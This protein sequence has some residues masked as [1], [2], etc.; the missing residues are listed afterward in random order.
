MTPWWV[1]SP[2]TL[3][4]VR[5]SNDLTTL[6]KDD[7]TTIND[8][9]NNSNN[10]FSE[11]N[12]N[13]P[14]DTKNIEWSVV[15]LKF[16]N[17]PIVHK[18]SSDKWQTFINPKGPQL[19]TVSTYNFIK[20]ESMP[21]GLNLSNQLLTK[22]KPFKSSFSNLSSPLHSICQFSTNNNSRTIAK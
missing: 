6:K 9:I 1:W 13:K 15:N 16:L 10:L 8:D 14:S 3:E 12:Y 4:Y 18:A 19:E 20:S 11:V 5:A 2:F 22:S 7:K 17:T 21:A